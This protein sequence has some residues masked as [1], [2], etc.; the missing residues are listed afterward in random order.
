M[1]IAGVEIKKHKYEKTLKIFSSQNKSFY[2]L[3]KISKSTVLN[4]MVVDL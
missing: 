1:E 3:H 2:N 4:T